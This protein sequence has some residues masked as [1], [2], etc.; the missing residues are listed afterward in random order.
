VAAGAPSSDR[1]DLAVADVAAQAHDR[2]AEL[3]ERTWTRVR[4]TMREAASWDG[5]LDA[6]GPDIGEANL[7]VLAGLLADDVADER[8]AAPMLAL[9]RAR[10]F[11]RLGVPLTDLLR[12]YQV[13]HE[14][15]REFY[16]EVL[17]GH[18]DTPGD[19]T[20]SAARVSAATFRFLHAVTEQV[21]AAYDEELRRERDTGGR[22]RR[23]TVAGLLAGGPADPDLVAVRLGLDLSLAHTALVAWGP[24]MEADA[25]LAA[26]PFGALET[27]LE[28][29]AA[30]VGVAR[31]LV[32]AS[33][34]STAWAWLTRSPAL[35]GVGS[36]DQQVADLAP[37]VLA[38]GAA[39]VRLACGSELPGLAGFRRSHQEAEVA[40]HAA[41]L[42]PAGSAAV[43]YDDVALVAL[44]GQ[45]PGLAR[46]FV[47]R[48]LGGLAAGD[49]A[50]GRL[51]ATLE[52]YLGEESSAS[53]AGERLGV[54]KNT[55]VYRLRQAETARGAPLHH[56]R[57]ELEAALRLAR[58]LPGLLDPGPR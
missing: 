46:A 28:G 23:E 54:H 12:A 50:S 55:V 5:T 34:W 29:V 30:A 27:A 43:R 24:D 10:Q 51:R 58:T 11:A 14:V 20:R 45:D 40:R 6:A 31:P 32:I 21:A 3:G 7:R 52:A 35:A 48:E 2:A 41:G 53:R 33:S 9:A 4:A 37:H 8:V 36:L 18:A 42:D 25:D 1:A 56:R 57:L 22:L 39:G 19:L 13:G 15:W 17:A 47:A 16:V 38:A 26:D 49:E 44:L